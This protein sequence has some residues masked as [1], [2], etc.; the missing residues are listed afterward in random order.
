MAEAGSKVVELGKRLRFLREKAGL[1]QEEVARRMKLT[2]KRSHTMVSRLERGQME[3]VLLLTIDR[4]LRAGN[5]H[6]TQIADIPDLDIAA[7]VQAC[8]LAG[9]RARLTFAL[10]CAIVVS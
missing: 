10:G 8:V 1:K 6:W 7:R 5:A 2:G 9:F 3:N 4:Y